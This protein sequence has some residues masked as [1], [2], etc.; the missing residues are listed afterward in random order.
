MSKVKE[1]EARLFTW[2]PFALTASWD[3][4]GLLVG[5][6]EQEVSC[7]LVALDITEEVVEEALEKNAQL[8]VSHHPVMNCTWSPVQTVR[9]DDRR[10]RIL[11]KLIQSNVAVICMHTNLDAA[12]GGVNDL[13]AEKLGLMDVSILS[14]DKIGRIGTLK[15]EIPLVVFTQTVVESLKCNG[16]RYVDGG[17]PVH[18]V[19]VGGGACGEYINCALSAGCD[20]FVTAD[21]KYHVFLNYAGQINLID[22]GHFPTEQVVCPA[23]VRRLDA[24]FPRLE[25]LLSARHSR[26]IIQY[27]VK[28]K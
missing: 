4:V 1:I 25:I 8:I 28:E 20:T 3:N 22:A 2:A 12:D 26:E 21:L 23:I 14:E 27:C 6:P 19:A 13:L 7:V 18:R 11:T 16:L 15:C 5:N 24:D 9:T 10:G 17:R